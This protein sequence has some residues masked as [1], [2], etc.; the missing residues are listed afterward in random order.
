MDH[1]ASRKPSMEET[2]EAGF[3]RSAQRGDRVAFLALA[4]RHLHSVYRIAY[5][6]TRSPEDARA[7]TLD[8]FVRAWKGIRHILEGQ[9]FYLWVTRITRNLCVS[10][11]RREGGAVA[12]GHVS[13]D[14]AGRCQQAFESLPIE[15]QHALVLRLVERLSYAGIGQALDLPSGFVMGRIAA[16]RAELQS[17]LGG[18]T[19][20]EPCVT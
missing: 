4:R 14:A 8:T 15:H 10:H 20:D 9:V 7:L 19:G 2:E 17:R 13:G 11:R 3:V 1:I 18:A 6:M 16:A 5:A 12:V